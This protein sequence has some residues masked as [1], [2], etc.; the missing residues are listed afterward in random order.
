MRLPEHNSF[1]E[2]QKYRNTI[3][4]KEF[5]PVVTNKNIQ[6]DPIPGI[7]ESFL[8][9]NESALAFD[10]NLSKM[11][12]PFGLN[13]QSVHRA[14]CDVIWLYSI[15]TVNA[16]AIL[17]GTFI[18]AFNNQ[19]EAT[20][21]FIQH[22]KKRHSSERRGAYIYHS[23]PLSPELENELHQFTRGQF[24]QTEKILPTGD[25]EDLSVIITKA[26]N[27]MAVQ[28]IFIGN[29]DFLPLQDDYYPLR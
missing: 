4:T 16:E 13:I 11:P 29:E 12:D 9:G 2:L 5:L 1:V 22:E 14:I 24:G 3:T 19:R 25:E 17:H 21:Q 18:H 10:I 8:I 7:S 26:D 27:T 28:S 20:Q 23:K 15:E 6:I